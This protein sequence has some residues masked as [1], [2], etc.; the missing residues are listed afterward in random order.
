MKRI[1]V[2]CSSRLDVRKEYIDAA[3]AL[4]EEI[5]RRGAEMV[6]G[7]SQCGLMKVTADAV[8]SAGGRTVGVVPQAIIDKGWAADDDVTFYTANL[9]DRK[10]TMQREADVFVALPGGIGTLDEIFTMVATNTFGYHSKK[11]ILYNVCGFWEPVINALKAYDAEKMLD[12]QWQ[13]RLCTA[14][15][16]EEL[17]KIIF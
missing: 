10:A 3:R 13:S 5:G 6:Y 9:D 1:G 16:P 15:T 11:V 7:G 8:H 4:G 12:S 17:Y 14:S 2:F